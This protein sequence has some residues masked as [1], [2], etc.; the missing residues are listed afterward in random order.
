MP[1]SYGLVGQASLWDMLLIGDCV[2]GPSVLWVMPA[3][4]DGPWVE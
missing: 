4:S 1:L 3:W 2:G